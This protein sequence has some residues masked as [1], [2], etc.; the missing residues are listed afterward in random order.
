MT[1]R[2]FW[3]YVILWILMAVLPMLW[4]EFF[5]DER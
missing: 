3:F 4:E 2:E 1:A 5:P